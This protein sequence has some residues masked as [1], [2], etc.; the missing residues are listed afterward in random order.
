[1]EKPYAD[2]EKRQRGWSSSDEEGT[3]GGRP[4]VGCGYSSFTRMNSGPRR[5]GHKVLLLRLF[6]DET[7]DCFQYQWEMLSSEK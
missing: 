5:A 3:R 6:L 2:L 4:S 1:M 7:H